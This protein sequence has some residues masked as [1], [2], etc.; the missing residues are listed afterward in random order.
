MYVDSVKNFYI[1][2][3]NSAF[4]QKDA[5]IT[6][7][8]SENKKALLELQSHYHNK[9]LEEFVTDNNETTKIF[10]YKGELIR[11]LDPIYS[12]PTHKFIRAQFYS[13]TKLIFGSRF[14]TYDV[15]VLVLWTMTLLLYVALYFRLL[16][17]LLDFNLFNNLNHLKRNSD[18]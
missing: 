1:D 3:Y 6:R 2:Y 18:Y 5:K 11:K 13:P 15:N 16:K 7:L 17:K 12:D 14:Y 9:S 10:E 8:Q 4:N